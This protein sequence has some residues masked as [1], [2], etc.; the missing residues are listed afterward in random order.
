MMSFQKTPATIPYQ[1]LWGK[2]LSRVCWQDEC[3]DLMWHNPQKWHSITFAISTCHW[4]EATYRSCPHSRGGDHTSKPITA[5]GLW[6]LSATVSSETL[7]TCRLVP[8]HSMSPSYFL[9]FFLSALHSGNILIFIQLHKF[10]FS[11]IESWFICC[12]LYF[13]SFCLFLFPE[14]LMFFILPKLF[15]IALHFFITI[16]YLP[17]FP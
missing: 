10:F 7:I 1:T 12:I 9:S 3:D 4:L 5:R 16:Q 11:C 13:Q 2:S 6:G 14:C 8:P 15:L 17:L